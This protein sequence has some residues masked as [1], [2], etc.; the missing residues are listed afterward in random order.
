MFY[1]DKSCLI[2]IY[3]EINLQF[4]S[5]V[6]PEINLAH[7]AAVDKAFVQCEGSVQVMG[8]VRESTL[9]GELEIVPEELLVGRMS[10]VLDDGLGALARILATQISYTLLCDE[11][12]H[13]VLGV[14]DV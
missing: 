14:V 11:H 7:V 4:K 9:V 5:I 6:F 3:K 10:T 13:G 2:P 8:S 12:L 1:H